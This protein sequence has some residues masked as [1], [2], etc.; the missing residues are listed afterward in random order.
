M[1]T[2]TGI[3]VTVK[4]STGWERAEVVKRN[5]RTVWVKLESGQ[6]IKRRWSQV[7]GVRDQQ[8]QRARA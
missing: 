1:A 6:T 3:L 4:V 8:L 5:V 2:G 7:Q